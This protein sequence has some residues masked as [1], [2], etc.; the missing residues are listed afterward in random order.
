MK[1]KW[2]A[3]VVDGRGKIGG[4]VASK[5]K[6]GSYMRNKVTPSNPQ[7]VTQTA[8][9]QLFGAISQQW[10]GLSQTVR[11]GWNAAVSD[12]QTTNIFGDLV[13]PSGKALFQKLNNQAQSAGYP[14]VT[15]VPA[16]AEMVEGVVTSAVFE[17]GLG[18][19]VLTG[20]YA[21]AGARIV[22]FA[23]PK[24]SKGTTF[25]K[26]KLRQLYTETGNGYGADESYANWSAKNGAPV[27]GDNIY[28]G[29]KYVLPNGQ[30]SPMQIVKAEV[31]N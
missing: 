12:W 17:L 24:L 30:A 1:I 2:G 4:Q 5:N 14:A 15:T 19:L 28:I 16:K 23:T 31:V 29:V 9:R 13:S 20:A 7:T 6:S 27:I 22:V 8:V 26:N 3:L 10:S 11:N 25:V 21:G 18:E